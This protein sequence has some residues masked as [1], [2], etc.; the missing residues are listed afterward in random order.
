MSHNLEIGKEGYAVCMKNVN[1]IVETYQS[2][3][4]STDKTKAIGYNVPFESIL[5]TT[6]KNGLHI[7]EFSIVTRLNLIGSAIETPLDI[8]IRLTKHEENPA[9]SRGIDLDRFDVCP[10]ELKEE[11]HNACIP[12]LQF[13]RIVQVPRIDL[14][15]G[16]GFYVL[17]I[18]AR[19][20]GSE[21]KYVIQ[22]MAPLLVVE[23]AP[24]EIIKQ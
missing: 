5:A 18:L 16:A 3:I 22:S 10:I 7:A 15:R 19:P 20:K 21:D 14:L 8:K 13:Q 6:D 17:K 11:I 23:N 9:E 2:V 1:A 12:F 4:L 24:Q